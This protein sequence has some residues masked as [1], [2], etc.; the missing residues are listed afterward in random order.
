LDYPCF[1]DPKHQEWNIDDTRWGE[2]LESIRKDDV[3]YFFGILKEDLNTL[4]IKLNII[5]WKQ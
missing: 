5:L 1:I 3:E 4:I 2:F